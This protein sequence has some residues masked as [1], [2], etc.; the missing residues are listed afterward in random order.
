MTSY[1]NFSFLQHLRFSAF[2]SDHASTTSPQS[3]SDPDYDIDDV[4]GESQGSWKQGLAETCFFYSQNLPTVALLL[5]RAGLSLA[6]LFAFSSATPTLPFVN[7]G[8]V[9]RRD[10]TFFR[11]DGALTDYTRGVLIANAAWTGWRIII[12]LGSWLG[13][14][15]F[16]NQRLGGLCGPRHAWEESEQEKTRSIYSEAASE[17]G[18]YRGSFYHTGEGNTEYGGDEL[19]WEWREVTRA[20]VQ[21]AFEFCMTTQ[22]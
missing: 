8:S 14:W 13:L 18:A 1:T 22:K 11:Q 4:D 15:I 7:S 9:F 20:R 16:S 21:D 3:P 6:L 19:P 12:L 17:Y 5:P 10:A 2:V